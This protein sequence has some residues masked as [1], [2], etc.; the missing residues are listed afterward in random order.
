MQR[1]RG[2]GMQTTDI[3]LRSLLSRHLVTQDEALL[4]ASSR[5]EVFARPA[6]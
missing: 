6:H 1:C 4:H 5:G 2:L 3:A